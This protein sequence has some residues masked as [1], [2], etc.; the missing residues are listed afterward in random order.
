VDLLKS[1][2]PLKY[3]C[4]YKTGGKALFFAEPFT[5]SELFEILDFAEKK[6]LNIFIYG[7]G[8][9]ILFSD[10][11]FEA[12]V[13]STSRLNNYIL[14]NKNEF[15]V[16]AGV[17]LDEF[18]EYS[19]IEGF[20]GLENL[21]G[22]PGCIGGNIVMNAG[23]F[24]SEIKDVVENITVLDNGK[25]ITLN[26]DEIGFGYR[27][28][29][30][31]LNKVV[32][33]AKIKL[34]ICKFRNCFQKRKEILQ[35][36]KEKQPLDFPSCGSVFKRPE[37]NFAGALIESCGLKGFSLG[38]AKISEK[39]ANFILNY[40]NANSSDIYTLINHVKETVFIQTGILL[41]EE[42]RLINFD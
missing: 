24:G 7:K 1:N 26:N 4:F 42:V 34:T 37:N 6:N 2:E 31:L 17:S 5:T 20:E 11:D 19:I 40:N 38:G 33:S 9:N 25:I 8:S 41:E 35:K 12:V 10:K 16:G 21:S 3:H 23:A 22:I 14:R 29:E 18:V 32:L 15:I 28:T 27:K 30:N 39:H 36:R 13:I